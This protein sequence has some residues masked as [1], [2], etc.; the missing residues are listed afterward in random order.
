MEDRIVSILQSEWDRLIKVEN[1]LNKLLD[2][3]ECM[4]DR[5]IKLILE[6]VYDGSI[7]TI[8]L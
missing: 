7:K 4:D 8:R 2:V 5:N 1:N 6:G 3:I